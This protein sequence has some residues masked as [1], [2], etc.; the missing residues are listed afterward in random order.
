VRRDWAELARRVVQSVATGA[1]V[2][3]LVAMVL[4]YSGLRAFYIGCGLPDWMASL[5][6]LCVDLLALVAYVA[7]L[8]LGGYYPAVVV[9]LTVAASAAAQGFHVTQGGFHSQITNVLVLG[10]AGAS[11]MIC[12]GLAGHLFF[13]IVKRS[14]P[15]DFI[16]SLRDG[17]PTLYAERPTL[18]LPP[19]NPP[20]AEIE[21]ED[22]PEMDK[23]LVDYDN[24]LTRQ[25]GQRTQTAQ[26]VHRPPVVTR[27]VA[28]SAQRG[29]CAANCQHHRGQ[30][31]GKSQRYR[32]LNTLQGK[33]DECPFCMQTREDGNA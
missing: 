31:V 15:V 5:S 13:M 25:N 4:S 18:S 14:L 17:A 16:E 10:L 22:W 29:P 3:L 12:A 19:S 21:T 28:P 9:G 27:R 1:G 8:A 6:P 7:W 2:L 24:D 26:R 33:R 23:L 30:E 11:P 32:C 20:P